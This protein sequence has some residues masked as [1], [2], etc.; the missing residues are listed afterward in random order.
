MNGK[1]NVFLIYIPIKV[2]QELK[3]IHVLAHFSSKNNMRAYLGFALNADF[4]RVHSVQV[5]TSQPKGIL[6]N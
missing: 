3:E 4:T 1:L 5:Q 2:L 6:G